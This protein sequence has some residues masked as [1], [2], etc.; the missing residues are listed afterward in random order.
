M[1][2]REI[3]LSVV[4]PTFNYGHMLRRSVES[5]LAQLI[6]GSELVV[7]DDGSTDETPR[8]LEAIAADRSAGFRWLRQD[9]AGAAAARNRGLDA[10]LGRFVFFLDS[11]DELLPGAL[12]ALDAAIRKY[13]DATV[14]VGGRLSHWSDGREKAHAPPRG[15]GPDPCARVADYL[16][17]KAVSI[18]HGSVAVHRDLIERRPYPETF[19]GRED[20]PVMAY[21]LA[22]G[23]IVCVEAN[24]GRKH[25]HSDSLRHTVNKISEPLER[26]LADEIFL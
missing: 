4:I 7:V 14:L 5:V 17:R 12:A 10:S 13:P 8:I 25:K 6:E 19:R 3:L 26:A 2:D 1:T 9:N 23:R 20:L 15:L 21:W 22:W 11:D 24:L 16:L 18:S